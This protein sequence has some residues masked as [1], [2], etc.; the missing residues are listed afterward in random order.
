MIKVMNKLSM[1]Y[2]AF[3]FVHSYRFEGTKL[4]KEDTKFFE[5]YTKENMLGRSCV[6]EILQFS[7]P[8]RVVFLF[9]F[10]P[11]W[12]DMAICVSREEW[13]NLNRIVERLLQ[14]HC[15][16]LLNPKDLRKLLEGCRSLPESYYYGLNFMKNVCCL[17]FPRDPREKYTASSKKF[18]S[19][20][21]PQEMA[22]LI[23]ARN[24]V[25]SSI[26]FDNYS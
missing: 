23:L 8:F 11:T 2:W 25:Q 13:V 7:N 15:S 21:D 19:F 24:V 6:V 20:N 12:P 5:P 10:D 26:Y 22:S 4:K 18:D 14:K 3:A 9:F 16:L 1:A 17:C